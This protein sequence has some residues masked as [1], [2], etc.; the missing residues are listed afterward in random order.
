MQRHRRRVLRAA[1]AGACASAGA[2]GARAQQYPDKPIRLVIPYPPGTGTDTL[3]RHTARKLEERFGRPVVPENRAGSSGIVAAQAVIASPPDGY[4]L[5]FVA[6]APVATNAALFEKLPY[7]PV[8]DLTPIARV[9]QGSFGLVVPAA[10]PYRTA[11][12]LLAAAAAQPGKLNYGAGSAFYSIATERLLSLASARANNIAYKGAAPVLTD[13]AGGQIDFAL[14]E[15][16][17]LRPFVQSGK[18]RLLAVT[19][20]TRVAAEPDV[21]TLRESGY[22]TYTPVAWWAVFGPPAMPRP[23]VERLE[24]ALLEQFATEDTRRFLLENNLAPYPAD[25]RELAQF[26]KAEIE[27]EVGIVRDAKIPRQ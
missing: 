25:A 14:A 15:Y 7:D 18:L 2:T 4:T 10:S 13:L 23:V 27:R 26:Q 5:F 3:A 19:S 22:P 21:P 16:G 11:K 6:N 20:A 17:G 9:A 1:L 8:K 24:R 12:E